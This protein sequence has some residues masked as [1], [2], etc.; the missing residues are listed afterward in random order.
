MYKFRTLKKH[1]IENMS[2]ADSATYLQSD[3]KNVTKTGKIL[4]KFYLDELPQLFNILQGEMSFVGPRPRIPSVYEKDLSL[5]YTALRY[6]RGGITGL[7]QLTKATSLEDLPR[8]S[9]EYY[10]HCKTYTPIGL[11]QHDLE[12]IFNTIKVVIKAEGL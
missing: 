4:I 8:R 2:N 3:R 6:L 7:H 5:G 9:E 12:I 11:L 10:N 1:I